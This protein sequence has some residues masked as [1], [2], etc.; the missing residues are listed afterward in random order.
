M[1]YCFLLRH[2]QLISL[3]GLLFSKGSGRGEGSAGMKGRET[4]RDVLEIKRKEGK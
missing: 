2:V 3:G 1:P 4:G